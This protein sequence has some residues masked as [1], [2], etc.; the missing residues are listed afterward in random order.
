MVSKKGERRNRERTSAIKEPD[1]TSLDRRMKKTAEDRANKEKN[2]KFDG[3]KKTQLRIEL[4]STI[5][6][7]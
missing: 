6:A 2:W 4:I 5:S 1:L 3:N 7:Y